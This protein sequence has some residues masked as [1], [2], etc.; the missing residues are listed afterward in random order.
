MKLRTVYNLCVM[1]L[2]HIC[3]LLSGKKTTKSLTWWTTGMNMVI[4]AGKKRLQEAVNF[5]SGWPSHTLNVNNTKM[6]QI[7]FARI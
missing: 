6:P 2:I 4:L 1:T 3:W 7:I 5:T